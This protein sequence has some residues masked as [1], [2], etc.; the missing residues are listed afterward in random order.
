MPLRCAESD[1]YQTLQEGL[2]ILAAAESLCSARTEIGGGGLHGAAS[3]TLTLGRA[4]AAGRDT[5]DW[6]QSYVTPGTGC[7]ATSGSITVAKT[8]E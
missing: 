2:E 6:L 3:A 7:R 8:N 4:A 1:P 5:R